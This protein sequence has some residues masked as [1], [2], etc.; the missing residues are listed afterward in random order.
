MLAAW[1]VVVALSATAARDL[2]L[3]HEWE[4]VPEVSCKLNGETSFTCTEASCRIGAG[5]ARATFELSAD[6]AKGFRFELSGR[7]SCRFSVAPAEARGIRG[8][9]RRGRGEFRG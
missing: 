5:G 8:A 3:G 6:Y 4:V 9:F 7:P 2:P 1:M